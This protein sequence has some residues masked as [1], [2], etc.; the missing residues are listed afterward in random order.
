M[1]RVSDFANPLQRVG[2]GVFVLRRCHPVRCR[3]N[4]AHLR[5]SRP[6][7]GLGFQ[8]EVLQTL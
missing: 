6:D 1:T 2:V 8:V 4:M 7:A 5:H 3:T